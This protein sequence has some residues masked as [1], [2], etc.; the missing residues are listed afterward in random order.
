MVPLVLGVTSAPP[1]CVLSVS[2]L[3]L[4]RLGGAASRL[5]P[6]RWIPSQVI[7][8]H[9]KLISSQSHPHLL[10]RIRCWIRC[11][12]WLSRFKLTSG[13]P[14][15]GSQQQWQVIIII[16]LIF[17]NRNLNVSTLQQCP[18]FASKR[19]ILELKDNN[20]HTRS[21]LFHTGSCDFSISLYLWS[22]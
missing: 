19:N 6:L 13:A 14:S 21:L 18:Q 7:H 1:T 17:F 2:C 4:L 20:S 9:L 5:S 16:N 3:S 22:K 15:L 12:S 10:W 8:T 11:W